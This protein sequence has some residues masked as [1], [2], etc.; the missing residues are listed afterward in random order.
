MIVLIPVLLVMIFL[1]EGYLEGYLN[2]RLCN[3][4]RHKSCQSFSVNALWCGR[5]LL[6][7]LAL[8]API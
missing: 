5:Q 4:S 7:F 3:L 8:S 1:L 6:A 2:I